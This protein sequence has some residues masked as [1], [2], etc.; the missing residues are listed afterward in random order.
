VRF[1]T[2]EEMMQGIKDR[3]TGA[4]RA[5]LFEKWS[6]TG[7]LRGLP[8]GLQERLAEVIEERWGKDVRWG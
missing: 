7:L 1:F 4:R 5:R 8:R 3:E 6:R 2:I